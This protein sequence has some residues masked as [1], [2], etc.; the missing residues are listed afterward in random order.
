MLFLQFNNIFKL[1][2]TIKYEFLKYEKRSEKI[3]H[4]LDKHLGDNFLLFKE[5][6]KQLLEDIEPKNLASYFEMVVKGSPGLK[7]TIVN[8]DNKIL[9]QRHLN[10][11]IG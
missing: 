7:F 10:V 3:I 4:E 9:S 11:E 6:F 8:E 1:F 2:K 5:N